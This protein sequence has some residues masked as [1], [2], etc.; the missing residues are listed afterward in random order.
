M[1]YGYFPL[2]SDDM[3]KRTDARLRTSLLLNKRNDFLVEHLPVVKYSYYRQSDEPNISILL[4]L[5]EE[6]GEH[7]ADHPQSGEDGGL[8]PMFD[9]REG[10]GR[11]GG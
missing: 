10:L 3:D 4:T 7:H 1:F 2:I 8:Q 5:I 11:F 6:I 9:L